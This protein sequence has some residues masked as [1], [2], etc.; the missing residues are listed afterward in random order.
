M[1]TRP[2]PVVAPPTRRTVLKWLGGASA[3]PVAPPWAGPVAALG[4]WLVTTAASARSAAEAGKARAPALLLARVAPPDIDPAPYLVSE[5]L[6]GVRAWWDGARCLTRRGH[7][8]ALPPWFRAVLPERPL[9]GELWWARGRF[10]ELSGLL[11][12]GDALDDPRWRALSYRLFE[13]PGA[14]GPFEARAQALADSTRQL[15]R[16][17]LVAAEQRRPADNAALQAWL[18][19]VVAGGGEGLMLHRAD[20]PYV[21]GRSDLLLKLKPEQ[22][23]EAVVIA[24]LP[25]KGKHAGRLGALRVRMV[26]GGQVFALGTG[27][28]DALRDH[29]PPLGSTVVYRYR[30]LT[31]TG[32]PRFA[33]FWRMG[34]GW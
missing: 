3:G 7:E 12:Q 6:D 1:D 9:D 13:L 24:H 10:D 26:E 30:G 8:I 18:A 16:P 11:R 17:W 20:A 34:E 5:K 29:P 19:E 25:G 21:T 4:L 27:L 22:D 28:P 2:I 15:D 32:L 23:A 14:P 33:S 31:P